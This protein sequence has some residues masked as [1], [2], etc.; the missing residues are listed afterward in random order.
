[1]V[2]HGIESVRSRVYSD[3]VDGRLCFVVFAKAGWEDERLHFIRK[4][5]WLHGLR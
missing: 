1:M 5:H 4:G 2:C 3:K